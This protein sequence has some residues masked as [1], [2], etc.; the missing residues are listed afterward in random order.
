MALLYGMRPEMTIFA[1]MH[2]NMKKRYFYSACVLTL[3]FFFESAR[4]QF[5]PSPVI[6]DFTFQTLE[7]KLFTKKDLASDKKTVFILFDVT[8]EHCQH[9]MEAIG[10]RYSSFRKVALYLVSMDTRPAI[11]KFMATYGKELYRKSNVTVL[12]DFKPEFIQKFSP[13]KYPAIYVYSKTGSLIQFF[14]GQKDVKD[15]EKVVK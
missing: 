15:I 4:A 7:G 11:E 12:Q 10:K 14:S 8:C 5:T 3:I 1:A 2:W 6:P 13:D 9:E